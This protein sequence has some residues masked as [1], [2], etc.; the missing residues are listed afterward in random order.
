M[1][2]FF[3]KI[4]DHRVPFS[5]FFIIA[6]A[7]SFFFLPS[8]SL[9][10]ESSAEPK[11]LTNSI[12]F[13]KRRGRGDADHEPVKSPPA[14]EEQPKLHIAVSIPPTLCQVETLIYE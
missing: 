11:V 14:L 9:A 5:L 8:L 13:C 6:F 7:L 3:K 4:I 10:L 2:A 12:L 1:T